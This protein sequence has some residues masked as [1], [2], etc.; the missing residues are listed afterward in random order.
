[1]TTPFRPAA[2]ARPSASGYALRAW[3]ARLKTYT[4]S[5]DAAA[6]SLPCPTERLGKVGSVIRLPPALGTPQGRR[7]EAA[8]LSWTT[9]PSGKGL[10][11]EAE[12]GCSRKVSKQPSGL[13]PDFLWHAWG[14]IR[15]RQV[16]EELARFKDSTCALMRALSLS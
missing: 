9:E 1:M 7:S 4:T 14:H 12:L 10:V 13:T 5:W 2:A 8:C 3:P 11:H 6:T 16:L 15:T